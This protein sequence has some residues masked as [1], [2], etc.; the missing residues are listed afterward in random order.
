MVKTSA[1]NQR[2]LTKTL[3]LKLRT[4]RKSTHVATKVLDKIVDPKLR[5]ELHNF[6]GFEA[7]V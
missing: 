1:S 4:T 6:T 7:R 3:E 5:H 2:K